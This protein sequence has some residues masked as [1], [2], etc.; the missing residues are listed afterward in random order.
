MEKIKTVNLTFT[1]NAK[2]IIVGK[3]IKIWVGDSSFTIPKGFETDLASIPRFLWW[4]IAPTDWGILVPAIFHD[5]TYRE[6]LFQREDCDSAFL[7]KMLDFK[8]PFYKAFIVYVAVRVFGGK[9]YK[10]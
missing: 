7:V 4:F 10:K 1:P 3:A 5:M 8:F 9:F 6:N 2:K